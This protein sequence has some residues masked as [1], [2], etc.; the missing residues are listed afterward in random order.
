VSPLA[1]LRTKPWW[2]AA[3]GAELDVRVHELVEYAFRHRE[4]DCRA[5]AAGYPPRPHV[6]AAIERVLAWRDERILRSRAAWLR[7]EQ[8]QRDEITWDELG[9][10]A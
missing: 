6:G 7:A 3:D 4:A 9:G 1:D 8:D 10:A 5:C 2:T